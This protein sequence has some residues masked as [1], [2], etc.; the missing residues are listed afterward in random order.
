MHVFQP[1]TDLTRA[2]AFL[3][4]FLGALMIA[5]SR[6]ADYRHD[7]YDVT[8]GSILGVLTAYFCYR[9]YYPSILSPNCDVP[10]DRGSLAMA[11]GFRRLADDEEQ[12]AYDNESITRDSHDHGYGRSPRP[13]MGRSRD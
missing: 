6:L 3:A 13:E 10:Y 8:G 9:R 11:D 5:L 12:L 1:R 7:V 4:P 2:L